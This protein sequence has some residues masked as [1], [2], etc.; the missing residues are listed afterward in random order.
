MEKS[1]Q[2]TVKKQKLA[3]K[4]RR[5]RRNKINLFVSEKLEKRVEEKAWNIFM[6]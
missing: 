6:F 5:K 3:R 4:T 1:E 2:W